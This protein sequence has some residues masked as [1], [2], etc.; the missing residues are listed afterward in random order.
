MAAARL[1]SDRRREAVMRKMREIDFFDFLKRD[2]EIESLLWRTDD[3]AGE[4]ASPEHEEA[5][6]LTEV[7]AAAE[8]GTHAGQEAILR[9][10]P[11][12]AS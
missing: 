11:S 5:A 6:R 8:P 1:T 3:P 4:V 9:S 10:P 12:G 2:A 7:A